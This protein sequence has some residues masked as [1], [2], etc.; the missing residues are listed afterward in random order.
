NIS[1]RKNI[2]QTRVGAFS[3]MFERIRPLNV[4]G[5]ANL[6]G[7]LAR[8]SKGVSV[9]FE[10][11]KPTV[12]GGDHFESDTMVAIP[13]ARF[14]SSYSQ[15]LRTDYE[16]NRIDENLAP[17]VTNYSPFLIVN[18]VHASPIADDIYDL[19]YL[20]TKCMAIADCDHPTYFSVLNHLLGRPVKQFAFDVPK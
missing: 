17:I 18:S 8:K 1:F 12:F 4:A 2:M 10:W 11:L 5:M 9:S 7:I 20:P 19:S 6:S 15:D 13:S 14:D 16:S 3:E